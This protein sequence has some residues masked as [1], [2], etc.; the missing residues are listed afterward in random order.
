MI[1]T[2]K[3]ANHTVYSDVQGCVPVV[4]LHPKGLRAGGRNKL[5]LTGKLHR[6]ES[7]ST[8]VKS[9]VYRLGTKIEVE[10]FTL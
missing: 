3:C 5:L 9:S 10:N 2:H 7:I 4:T 1:Q 6:G 8:E